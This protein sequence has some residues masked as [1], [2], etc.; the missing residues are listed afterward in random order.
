MPLSKLPE[1]TGGPYFARAL[2][3]ARSVD[4]SGVLTRWASLILWPAMAFLW[5]RCGIGSKSAARWTSQRRH[6]KHEERWHGKGGP[7][8]SL[9]WVGCRSRAGQFSLEAHYVRGGAAGATDARR[10]LREEAAAEPLWTMTAGECSITRQSTARCVLSHRCQRDIARRMWRT[11]TC[12]KRCG[13]VWRPGV[14][15]RLAP[16]DGQA[17]KAGHEIDGANGDQH[18]QDQEWT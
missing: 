14:S 10:D 7:A 6:A 5:A 9:A 15:A 8:T 13:R 12:W 3:E 18:P 16:D 2:F 11:A 17:E 4:H 1:A